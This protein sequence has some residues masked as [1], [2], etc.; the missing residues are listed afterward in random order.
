M[1]DGEKGTKPGQAAAELLP[2]LTQLAE[3][4]AAVWKGLKPKERAFV[5]GVAVGGSLLY[6][7]GK[8]KQDET[9]KQKLEGLAKERRARRPL[10]TILHAM[11]FATVQSPPDDRRYSDVV[12]AP[13]AGALPIDYP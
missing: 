5:A 1:S 8:V 2:P 9:Q 11:Q 13:G 6:L 4:A 7:H 10:D 3:L 12:A